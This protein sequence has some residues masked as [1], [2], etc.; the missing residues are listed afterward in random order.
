MRRGPARAGAWGVMG[1][2]HKF[3]ML[4]Y[5]AINKSCGAS[6]RFKGVVALHTR[7]G[8]GVEKGYRAEGRSMQLH[9]VSLVLPIEQ[10][11][12]G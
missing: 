7:M 3:E 12:S 2:S 8:V 1:K 9:Q 11:S 5:R 6:C 4:T 10:N